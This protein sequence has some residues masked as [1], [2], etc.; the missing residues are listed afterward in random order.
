MAG[1]LAIGRMS[2]EEKLRAL[3]ALWA[4]LSQDEAEIDS[5]DWHAD[6]LGETERLVREVKAKFSDWQTARRRIRR[7]AER[8]A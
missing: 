7:K 3:E 1:T 4:D 8:A 2:R 6:I 5:P